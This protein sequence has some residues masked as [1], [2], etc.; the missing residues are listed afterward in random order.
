MAKSEAKPEPGSASSSQELLAEVGDEEHLGFNDLV[1]VL[2]GMESDVRRL[3]QESYDS[4]P[5][6]RRTLYLLGA[7]TNGALPAHLRAVA[8]GH[9][10]RL[11][12]AD[13][14][15]S[16]GALSEQGQLRLRSGDLDG[17]V[18]HKLYECIAQLA[19]RLGEGAWP[20]LPEFLFAPATST[21]HKMAAMGVYAEAPS[22][23]ARQR[24][25]Y[26]RTARDTLVSKLEDKTASHENRTDAAVTLC[27]LLIENYNTDGAWQVLADSVTAMIRYL[28][29]CLERPCEE[30]LLACFVE[31]AGRCPELLKPH[32]DDLVDLCLQVIGDRAAPDI[33]R[34]QCMETVVA[35]SESSPVLMRAL[36]PARLSQ[37]VSRLFQMIAEGQDQLGASFGDE[38][39]RESLVAE[40][41]LLRL[42]SSLKGFTLIP[43]AADRICT[44]VGGKDWR[45]R[46]AALTALN[47]L[48][49]EEALPRFAG[50]VPSAERLVSSSFVPVLTCLR[51]PEPK[52][53]HAASTAIGHMAMRF[54]A[55]YARR[56]HDKVIPEL[57]EILTLETQPNVVCSATETLEEFL[58]ACPQDLVV[59]HLEAV[60]GKLNGLINTRARYLID[61][62]TAGS[63][64]TEAALQ[65]MA[66]VAQLVQANFRN[67]YDVS[68]PAV[69]ELITY[70]S[71]TGNEQVRWLALHSATR[72][73][74]AVGK[75]KFL[76]D[77]ATVTRAVLDLLASAQYRG[78][79]RL[80]S[81]AISV[82]HMTSRILVADGEDFMR[83][84]LPEVFKLLALHDSG[85]VECQAAVCT[86]LSWY[87]LHTPRALAPYGNE[88]IERVL[89]LLAAPGCTDRRDYLNKVLLHVVADILCTLI[90]LLKD[91][92]FTFFD[93]LAP[94]VSKLLTR[95]RAWTEHLDGLAVFNSV[96]SLGSPG[97]V[98]YRFYYLP[99]VVEHL[100]SNV[101]SVRNEA[102]R[103]VGTLADVGGN[104]FGP[105]CLSAVPALIAIMAN[106]KSRS[107]DESLSFEAAVIAMTA[108]L[109]HYWT[110]LGDVMRLDELFPRFLSWLGLL[111]SANWRRP[112]ELLCSLLERD[113]PV[114]MA[115]QAHVVQV[116]IDA[117]AKNRVVKGSALGGRVMACLRRLRQNSLPIEQRDA[118]SDFLSGDAEHC[119]TQ[120]VDCG[121]KS[122]A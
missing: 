94:L 38:L 72:I 7:V 96:L 29:S 107:P 36:D 97:C 116:L 70:L 37:L 53:R 27:S 21:A 4:L 20:E 119:L 51:D 47:A 55:E 44:M 104:T 18:R 63:A 16:Y 77:A 88:A 83:E 99:G 95:Q 68:M 113:E 11:L 54:S 35:L 79:G 92:Y 32:L 84:L 106:P 33:W 48:C 40:E 46:Y 74:L 111:R 9:L 5:A 24:R 100:E 122:V 117:F 115:D 17:S 114:V 109:E 112:L 22:V 75:E 73:G 85:L 62:G 78:S 3:T 50:R 98:R 15:A 110:P 23:F 108:I 58:S 14:Q 80:L 66:T 101:A 102:V 103:A 93:H 49:S 91:S 81:R 45:E 8:A 71:A 6:S 42:S 52:V 67:F 31:L 26:L 13:L 87:A 82:A 1:E 60:V 57:L 76:E 56:S 86:L 10:K 25:A 34:H 69:R 90:S 41:A 64:V 12:A 39:Q 105:E 120:S 89:P 28:A 121:S 19:L 65:T 30:R 59:A 118:L 61:S 43:T 2:R